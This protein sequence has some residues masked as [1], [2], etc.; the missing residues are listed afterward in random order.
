MRE[1][2]HEA[3]VVL[4]V[5]LLEGLDGVEKMSK[6]L[7]NYIG[8]D[9]APDSIFGKVMSISDEL[10]WKY[11]LLCTDLT[12]DEIEVRKG[13]V[14][15]GETHPMTA[16]RELAKLIVADF[17]SPADAER[18]EAEFTRIF[19]ERQTPSD[20]EEQSIES[21]SEP[22]PLIK[23]LTTFN[24]V[25]SNSEARRLVSQGGVTVDDQRVDDPRATL[26]ASDGKSYV[27]KAGKRRFVRVTFADRKG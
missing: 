11:Y 17:H 18:A 9:E 20:L 25:P 13:A 27:V 6:S 21:S 12:P 24:V 5:P 10:M 26:D 1:Y 15:G 22:M 14:A 3:Q 16:K 23:L 2:G 19:S 8:I 7:G 4:T